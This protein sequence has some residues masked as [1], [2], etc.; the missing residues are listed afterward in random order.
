MIKKHLENIQDAL[1]QKDLTKAT[2]L[3]EVAIKDMED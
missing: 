3:V 2:E 1:N